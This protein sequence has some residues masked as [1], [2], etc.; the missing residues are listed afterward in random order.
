MFVDLSQA[1]YLWIK[2]IIILESFCSL[3]SGVVLM[4][5][6]KHLEDLKPPK[7]S[8]FHQSGKE[9]KRKVSLTSVS[10]KRRSAKDVRVVLLI[11]CATFCVL[12]GGGWLYNFLDQKWPFSKRTKG[13][14]SKKPPCHLTYIFDPTANRVL[15]GNNCPITGLKPIFSNTPK[16]VSKW[17]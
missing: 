6:F 4:P 14:G 8:I 5:K 2:I 1:E 10:S 16:K 9:R 11:Y 13:G 7:W 15:S 12:Y 3:E 17:V